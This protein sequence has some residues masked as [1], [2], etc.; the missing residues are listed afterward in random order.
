MTNIFVDDGKPL[1]LK[2]HSEILF[3]EACVRFKILVPETR[4]VID[5]LV[6]V[7]KL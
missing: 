7:V 6:V 2:L 1:P 3:S 5:T 4:S